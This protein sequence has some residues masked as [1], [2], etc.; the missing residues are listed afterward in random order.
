MSLF[1]RAY[2]RGVNDELIRLGHVR[3]PTKFA[4]DEIADAV[5]EQMP[6]EPAGEPVSPETAAEVAATLVDAANKLVEETSGAGLAPEGAA[7]AP[8]EAAL[9]TSAAQD[10]DTRAAMQA[11]AVMVKSAEEVKLALGST[12]E[13]GDKG[14]LMTESPVG[15]T[16]MENRNRPDGKYVMGVG[17]TTYPVGEGA[18][19]TEQVPHPEGPSNSPGGDNSVVEQSKMGTALRDIIRKVAAEGSNYVGGDK[20][21]TPAQAA[22]T[23][24]TAK[25]DQQQRPGNYA[26]GARGQGW[27][28]VPPSAV[29]GTEEKHPHTPGETPGGTNSITAASKTGA[30]DPFIAL[31][32]KTA[33]EVASFLPGNMPEEQK[34]AH[35]R[36][37]MGMTDTERNDYLGLL[38][39]TAGATD[40]QA[41]AAVEKHAACATERHHY[42]NPY[43]HKREDRRRTNMKTGGELPP[44]LAA[45]IAKKKG[46]GETPEHEA[47]ETPAHETKETPAEEKKEEKKEE[48]KKEGSDLLSRIRRISQS[49]HASV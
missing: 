22:Q 48:E 25:L 15:E 42:E 38:H 47:K 16:I 2:S 49:S 23:D 40:D 18:V 31:F 43:G 9:K 44:A 36:Q 32:Q 5:G 6:Q 27:G 17:N 46:E 8:E 28:T 34:I 41:V 39:K 12:I 35:I 4:A 26:E 33:N 10:L 14:N 19:G 13:G 30:V 3:Y 24:F 1:K 7:P 29:V 11:Q 20:G 37:M 21:N 45:A